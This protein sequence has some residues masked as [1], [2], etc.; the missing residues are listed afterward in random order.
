[1]NANETLSISLDVNAPYLCLSNGLL[2]F[3]IIVIII[4]IVVVVFTSI[5]FIAYSYV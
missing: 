3:I 1:M 4:I 2:C 5:I